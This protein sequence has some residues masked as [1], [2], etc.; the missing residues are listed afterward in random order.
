MDGET[1][2]EKPSQLQKFAQRDRIET[3]PGSGPPDSGA[4]SF[5]L[6]VAED[7]L[8]PGP[9]LDCP[10][11]CGSATCS[12]P[13]PCHLPRASLDCEREGRGPPGLQAALGR[14]HLFFQKETLLRQEI[15]HLTFLLGPVVT[16]FVL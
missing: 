2:T 13:V 16:T 10:E 12:C 1:G 15:F 3:C 14:G 5:L 6:P 4:V 9:F 7:G 11:G 8:T